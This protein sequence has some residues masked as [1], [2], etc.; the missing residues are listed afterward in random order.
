MTPDQVRSAYR[1]MLTQTGETVTIRRFTGTG[2]A[3]PW[4]D[5]DVQACVVDYQPSELV[6]TI[7]QGDRRLIVLH[8]DLVDA[9]F[10]LPIGVGPNWKVVVR[11]KEL[12]IKSVDENTR[13]IAGA[14][15]AYEIQAGG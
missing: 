4:F 8:E 15:V 13:R 1:R 5:A 2:T 14:L 11:G 6:G 9:Q 12:Q 10:P 3:R 7:A